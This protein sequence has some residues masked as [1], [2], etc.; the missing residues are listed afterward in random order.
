[1]L[2]LYFQWRN[3]VEMFSQASLMYL[4]YIPDVVTRLAL[5]RPIIRH[6]DIFRFIGFVMYLDITYI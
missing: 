4:S 3:G 2:L 1:M 6:F 5:L